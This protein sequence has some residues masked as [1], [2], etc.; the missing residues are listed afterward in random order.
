MTR[1]ARVGG[2]LRAGYEGRD[3]GLLVW[4][5]IVARFPTPAVQPTST[6]DIA[7]A[8]TPRRTIVP[9]SSSDETPPPRGTRGMSS[10]D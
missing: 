9:A 7:A 2:A 1:P 8:K 3:D 4:N 6:Q 5:G 10:D